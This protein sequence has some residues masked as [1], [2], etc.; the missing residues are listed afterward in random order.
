MGSATKLGV[1]HIRVL[2]LTCLASVFASL[3]LG[4]GFRSGSGGPLNS[5]FEHQALRPNYTQTLDTS[6]P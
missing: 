2:S 4:S 1:Y 6:G 5:C 3:A